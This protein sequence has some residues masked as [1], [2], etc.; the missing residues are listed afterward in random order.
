LARRSK[1]TPQSTS[2]NRRRLPRSS[3][4]RYGRNPC[5]EGPTR[6]YPLRASTGGVSNTAVGA[7]ALTNN[8]TG[9]S[10]TAVGDNTLGA[11]VDPASLTNPEQIGSFNT[12]V[13][14]SALVS[15]TRGDDN[16]ALGGNALADNQ[17]GDANTALGV[18]ALEQNVGGQFN[19]AVG[20]GALS[21]STGN[22]NTAVG[23]NAGVNLIS[24]SNNTYIDNMGSS[25]ESN[26]MRIGT[27]STLTRTFIAGIRGTNV[28]GIGA[29]GEP[30]LI[31]PQGRLG[32]RTSSARYKRDIEAMGLRSQG[33]LQLRPVTFRYK[34]GH[35][36]GVTVRIDRRGGGES[37]S[38]VSDAR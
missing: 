22:N 24:G 30:V 37:L 35:E 2:R 3:S 15:N 36:G 32:I 13:G 10:N 25:S 1:P 26:T 4:F 11:T 21:N 16:T 17:T 6:L 14:A 29:G 28:A 8:T 9:S 34:A 23:E 31:N 33:L 18:S 7:N 38:R 5:A 12:A 27:S 19:T 20:V